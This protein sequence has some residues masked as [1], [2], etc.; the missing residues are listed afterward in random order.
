MES[1]LASGLFCASGD[2]AVQRV[3]VRRVGRLCQEFPLLVLEA[4]GHGALRTAT[5]QGFEGHQ[6]HQA[7]A[8]QRSMSLFFCCFAGDEVGENKLNG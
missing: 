5:H 4:S 3:A 8:L 7:L 1:T 6:G 2:T